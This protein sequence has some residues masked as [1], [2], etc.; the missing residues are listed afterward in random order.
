MPL[1]RLQLI[2]TEELNL[3]YENEGDS[4]AIQLRPGVAFC[5]HKF[6]ALISDLVRGAGVRYVRQ[7]NL[8]ILGESSDLN[9]V[10]F[11]SERGNLAVV[12]PVLLDIQRPVLLLQEGYRVPCGACGPLRSLGSLSGGAEP[13]VRSGR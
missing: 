6:H 3:L 8:T 2:G 1:W 4:S 7:R 10:L 9:E 5:F 11:G 12:R 13:R